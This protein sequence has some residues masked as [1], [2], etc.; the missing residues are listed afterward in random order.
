MKLSIIL[1]AASCLFAAY[2]DQPPANSGSGKSKAAEK[3]AAE[4]AAAA[5]KEAAEKE[6]A[7]KE[8][9]EKAAAEKAAAESAPAKDPLVMTISELRALAEAEQQA[10]R[11]AGGTSTNDP[12]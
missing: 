9:A 12:S 2:D 3:E 11:Q 1:A 4:K 10:F 6:A 5:E 7:E 8:A